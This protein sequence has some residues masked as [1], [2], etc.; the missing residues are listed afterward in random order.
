MKTYSDLK[1]ITFVFAGERATTGEPNARTGAMSKYGKYYAFSSVASAH[2]FA[3]TLQSPVVAVGSASK[4]RS[5]SLGMTVAS[6]IEHLSAAE[7]TA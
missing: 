4:L 2:E 6:Y 3:D 1:G 7:C 5:Y